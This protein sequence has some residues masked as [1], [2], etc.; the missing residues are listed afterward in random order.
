VHFLTLDTSISAAETPGVAL[1]II[2]SGLLATS[3]VP[4][5]ISGAELEMS[6]PSSHLFALSVNP[7]E[8]P[9]P[10]PRA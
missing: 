4:V 7:S 5:F 1:Q 3:R 9:T 2:F 10:P 8:I 6:Q